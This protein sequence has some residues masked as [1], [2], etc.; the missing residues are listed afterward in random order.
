M[1]GV[2]DLAASRFVFAACRSRDGRRL[3]APVQLRFR[4]VT[5]GERPAAF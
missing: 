1:R 4:F 5:N 3:V 2:A